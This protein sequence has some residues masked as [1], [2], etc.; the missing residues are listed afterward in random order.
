MKDAISRCRRR[1]FRPNRT[2]LRPATGREFCKL[3]T[4]VKTMKVLFTNVLSAALVAVPLCSAAQQSTPAPAATAPSAPPSVAAP[5]PGAPVQNS[6]TYVIGPDDSLQVS[7]WHEDKLSGTFPVRPDGMISISLVGDIPAAGK[8]PMDLAKD[9]TERLKAFITDPTVSVTVLAVNSKRVF[10]IGEVTKVGPIPLTSDMTALQAIS[11]AGGPTAYA[12]K[13]K[14]YILRVVNGKQT[15]IPFN[16]KKAL[17]GD[18][19]GIK[20]EPGDT[21]V[22]PG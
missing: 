17:S 20:L 6:T 8:T 9:L 22:V 15:K 4:G 16:Y 21:I 2:G 1:A 19:Q 12:K 11:V 14:I 13:S 18:A 3:T 10:L 7:V 5:Q